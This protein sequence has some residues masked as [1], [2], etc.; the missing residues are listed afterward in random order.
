LGQLFGGRVLSEEYET[1]R[2]LGFLIYIG[3]GVIDVGEI[4]PM[5][6]VLKLGNLHDETLL[7]RVV[8]TTKW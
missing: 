5:N 3:E 4:H 7:F 6:G 8:N 1:T 2:K